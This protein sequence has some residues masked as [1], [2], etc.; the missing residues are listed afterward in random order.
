MSPDVPKSG[1]HPLL[2]VPGVAPSSGHV[3]VDASFDNLRCPA[4]VMRHRF[5]DH[6]YMSDAN[7]DYYCFAATEIKPW[8]RE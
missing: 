4:A 8:R 5:G 6:I 2:G 1:W 7:Y 3:E